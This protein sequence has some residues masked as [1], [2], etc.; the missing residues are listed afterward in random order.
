[1]YFNIG[2]TM[3]HLLKRQ[4]NIIQ[5]SV[6]AHKY[7]SRVR[8]HSNSDFR[9]VGAVLQTVS[10]LFLYYFI[11]L[12]KYISKLFILFEKIVDA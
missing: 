6:F 9:S 11:K 2:R 10:S 12:P 8:L 5:V 7:K 1:M 4:V 3:K